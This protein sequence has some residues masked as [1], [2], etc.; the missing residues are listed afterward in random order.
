[1]MEETQA[2]LHKKRILRTG[3]LR[4]VAVVILSCTLLLTVALVLP[5][6]FGFVPYA[7]RTGSMEPTIPVG[8][9]LYVRPRKEAPEIGDVIA[10]QVAG[11]T[12][13]AHR[14]IDVQDG[15][16][17]TRGERNTTED[18]SPVSPSQV[19]GIYALH[20]PLIGYLFL[21]PAVKYSWLALAVCS[22]IYLMI[23]GR[24]RTRA[25]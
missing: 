23:S 16:Y 2:I 10:F 14:L 21:V 25:A 22:M 9:L 13:V 5:R 3:I 6:L 24:E 11:G 19:L 17:I 12:V 18:P 20:I 4:A 8:A 7:V 15:K 1:M